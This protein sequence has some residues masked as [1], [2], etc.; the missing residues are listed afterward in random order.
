[1]GIFRHVKIVTQPEEFGYETNVNPAEPFDEVQRYFLGSRIHSQIGY[2]FEKQEEVEIE[3][4]Y[5]VV[6]IIDLGLAEY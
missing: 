4:P 1:M 6:S 2:D 5:R 3:T